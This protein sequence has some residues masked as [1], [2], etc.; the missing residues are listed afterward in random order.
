MAAYYIFSSMTVPRGKHQKQARSQTLAEDQN[1]CK[2]ETFWSLFAR[3]VS[4]V[5]KSCITLTPEIGFHM[6]TL[7]LVF[8]LIEF[9]SLL[10]TFSTW[11][12]HL[13]KHFFTIQKT[14]SSSFDGTTLTEKFRSNIISYSRG[15]AISPFSFLKTSNV[16]RYEKL[17][18]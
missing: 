17:K 5:E 12:L 10:F 15:G 4:K 7:V 2:W 16:S 18:I 13:H 14:F 11:A 8:I 6:S 9:S 3:S 1:A